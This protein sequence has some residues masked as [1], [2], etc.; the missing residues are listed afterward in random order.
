MR[1][2]SYKW[3]SLVREQVNKFFTQGLRYLGVNLAVSRNELQT[4]EDAYMKISSYFGS[5]PFPM[6]ILNLWK[7]ITI[8]GEGCKLTYWLGQVD[9]LA[10][11]GV[12]G[13]L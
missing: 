3:D 12:N 2:S 13:I 9:T 11:L 6:L 10:G 5:V 4:I 7:L 8:D 1:N